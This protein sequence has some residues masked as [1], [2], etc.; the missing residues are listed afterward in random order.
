ML[1]ERE[2]RKARWTCAPTSGPRPGVIHSGDRRRKTRVRVGA[3]STWSFR[4]GPPSS[5]RVPRSPK[6]CSVL[7]LGHGLGRSSRMA[8]S[9]CLVAPASPIDQVALAI[10][11]RC[12]R[13]WRRAIRAQQREIFG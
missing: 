5:R 7:V 11:S 8:R 10:I 2:Q 9:S 12:R 6:R 1:M 4:P 13:R 3:P